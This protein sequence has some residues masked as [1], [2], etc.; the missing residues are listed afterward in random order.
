MVQDRWMLWCRHDHTPTHQGRSF[1]I[2][3]PEFGKACADCTRL[4]N[5][6]GTGK[7]CRLCVL[8]SYLELRYDVLAPRSAFGVS[9]A[10][11][12]AIVGFPRDAEIWGASRPSPGYLTSSL[13]SFVNG[14]IDSGDNRYDPDHMSYRDHYAVEFDGT[15]RAGQELAAGV[16][17]GPDA[18]HVILYRLLDASGLIYEAA[19]PAGGVA[20][21]ESAL[22]TSPG[23]WWRQRPYP[24]RVIG[25]RDADPKRVQVF[26]RAARRW[27]VNELSRGRGRPKGTT[28][29]SPAEWHVAY[30]RASAVLR[31]Q[32][33]QPRIDLL[34][35]E[36]GVS[37]ST[38]K[39]YKREYGVRPDSRE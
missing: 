3:S 37:S 10:Q 32:N 24:D 34:A 7:L 16:R 33:R 4:V 31:Q 18:G 1:L 2:G 22:R 9:D 26:E 29:Y 12:L 15:Y 17:G 35:N 14:R 25:G 20:E 13:P 28:T 6:A 23:R 36:I 19:L 8:T 30:E 21:P 39:K 38:F 27:L 11:W 5:M